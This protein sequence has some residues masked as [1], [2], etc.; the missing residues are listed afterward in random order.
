MKVV[1]RYVVRTDRGVLLGRYYDERT[2]ESYA[3]DASRRA[4]AMG[5]CA[6]TYEV[7]DLGPCDPQG[8][9]TDEESR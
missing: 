3:R 8:R 6:T 5:L 9:Y 1:Q 7:R 2:A 4:A